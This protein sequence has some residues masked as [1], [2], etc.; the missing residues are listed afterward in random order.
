MSKNKSN[1]IRNLPA[2]IKA[3]LGS[4]SGKAALA[5]TDIRVR[6]NTVKGKPK[7]NTVYRSNA[8]A[9]AFKKAVEV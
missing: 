5:R 3:Y 1:A 4:E 6:D 2:F 7:F 9:L 8:M